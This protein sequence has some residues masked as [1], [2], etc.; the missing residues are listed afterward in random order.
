MLAVEPE[1]AV[2]G[3]FC[4]KPTSIKSAENNAV[5]KKLEKFS[6]NPSFDSKFFPSL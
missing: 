2:G 4:R 3:A 1:V 6:Q 5:L